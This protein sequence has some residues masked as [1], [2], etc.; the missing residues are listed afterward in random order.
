VRRFVQI[1]TG[2]GKGKTTAAI[3][4]A[5]RAAGSGLRSFIIQ[6][7]KSYPYGEVESLKGLADWITIEQYGDDAFVMRKAP[8]SAEDLARAQKALARAREIMLRGSHD[9]VILDEVCVC[10]Y[11]ELLTV[12]DVMPFFNERPGHVELIMTGRYCP[13]EW[14]DRADLV[15][16]MR[17][18]KHYYREGVLARKGFES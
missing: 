7:M 15:T 16:E 12:Q 1:Y 14:I 11:F 10:V 18:I 3:G 8:P 4:Q 5:V 6:F 2:N 17:E 13:P 9:I